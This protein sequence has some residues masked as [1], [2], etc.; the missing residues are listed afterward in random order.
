MFTLY[1]ILIT[2]CLV[3]SLVFVSIEWLDY[4][5]SAQFMVPS[6]LRAA[7]VD[8]DNTNTGERDAVSSLAPVNDDGA[9]EGKR[10]QFLHVTATCYHTSSGVMVVA[11]STGDFALLDLNT[12]DCNVLH[13]LNIADQVRGR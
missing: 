12:N 8:P 3:T 7:A 13:S 1:F 11:C 10:S 4:R 5:C 6:L 2:T 9:T